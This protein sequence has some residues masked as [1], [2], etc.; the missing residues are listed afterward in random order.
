M[1]TLHEGLWEYLDL[2]H[3]LGFKMREASRLLL[4]FVDFMEARKV[5]YICNDLVAEWSQRP[6]IQR[7]EWARRLCFVRGFARHR[8]ATD[9]RTEI[10]PVTLLPHRSTRARPHLYTDQV[11][12]NLMR[13]ALKLPV[14]WPSTPL[15]PWVFYCPIGLL[16]A[17]ACLHC[18]PPSELSCRLPRTRRPS[19]SSAER[20]SAT[21]TW[22]K[23]VIRS[24]FARS[25]AEVAVV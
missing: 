22:H 21:H 7:A 18:T 9:S 15:R 10:P 23:A 19:L 4:Q 13:A 11:V 25:T 6:W 14:T 8:S 3:G 20:R 12:R 17:R 2:R 5:E 24:P 16:S 1:N